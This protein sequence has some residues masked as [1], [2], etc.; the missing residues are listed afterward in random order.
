[1]DKISKKTLGERIRELREAQD[2]SLRE[3]A[4]RLE[5]SPA[6][7]SDIE[8]GRRHPSE[9]VLMDIAKLLNATPEELKALDARPTVKEFKRLVDKNPAF[10]FAFR[11]VIDKEISPEELVALVENKG[12]RKK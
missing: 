12:K 1:M 7:L 11:K 6:F 9:R 8:L 10:G 3:F 4:K 2:W 5:I